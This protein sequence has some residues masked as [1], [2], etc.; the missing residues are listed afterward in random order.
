M[1]Q[2]MLTYGIHFIKIIP[3]T[4]FRLLQFSSNKFNLCIIE[5]V[6]NLIYVAYCLS[7]IKIIFEKIKLNLNKKCSYS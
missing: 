6:F 2:S 7:K 1:D 4:V 5:K 3:N